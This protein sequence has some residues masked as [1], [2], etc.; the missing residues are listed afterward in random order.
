MGAILQPRGVLAAQVVTVIKTAVAIG[1]GTNEDP[2]R[3]LY[4]YWSLEG[5]LLAQNDPCQDSSGG[6]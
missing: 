6:G 5:E 2:N 4:Q 3:Y 1:A